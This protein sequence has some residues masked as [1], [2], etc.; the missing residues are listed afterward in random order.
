MRVPLRAIAALPSGGVHCLL[1]PGLST[2][3][4]PFCR[5][6]Q[7]VSTAHRAAGAEAAL[8][9][10]ARGG[11]GGGGNGCT[12]IGCRGSGHRG[13]GMAAPGHGGNTLSSQCQPRPTLFTFSEA[14]LHDAR[15][16]AKVP[17]L[18]A[19]KSTCSW[20]S[21]WLCARLMWMGQSNEGR[22]GRRYPPRACKDPQCCAV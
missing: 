19:S 4:P 3:S 12:G 11:P 8:G 9:T 15:V 6:G 17:Q 13:W 5:M 20:S 2:S 14:T 22:G 18:C 21:C 7:C 1:L 10:Q 16:T